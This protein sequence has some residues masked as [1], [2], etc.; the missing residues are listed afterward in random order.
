MIADLL[1]EIVF[2]CKK[3]MS[4]K[5]EHDYEYKILKLKGVKNQ[6]F[7]HGMLQQNSHN[8][9]E[10]II[11]KQTHQYNSAIGTA[12]VQNTIITYVFVFSFST[13]LTPIYPQQV[14]VRSNH[15]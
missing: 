12:D 5:C 1:I 8:L 15:I 11:Q 13:I 10:N 2:G 4:M 6:T 3:I 9:I 7:S 14:Y